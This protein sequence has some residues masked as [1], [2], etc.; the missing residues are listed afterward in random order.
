MS[1]AKK[2]DILSLK[3]PFWTTKAI[4]NFAS[5]FDRQDSTHNAVFAVKNTVLL[6]KSAFFNDKSCI[7]N[8]ILLLKIPFY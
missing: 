3:T 2:N 8:G 1:F 7:L 6:T 4:E 5:Y